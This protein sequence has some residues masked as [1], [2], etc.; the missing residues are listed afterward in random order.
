MSIT[1]ASISLPAEI[2]N[3]IISNAVAESAV[4]RLARRI[5]LPGHGAAVPVITGDPTAYF[6]DEGGVK[7]NSDATMT[8]KTMKGRTIAI[9]EPFSNQFRRDNQ[10]LYNEMVARLPKLLAQ[11]FDQEVFNGTAVSG[12]DTLKGATGVSI[13]SDVWAG[14]VAARAAVEAADGELNGWAMSNQGITKLLGEKTSGGLPVYTAGV[15]E[16]EY[17]RL[18]GEPIVR[19][20]KAYA[21]NTKTTDEVLGFAGDWT[22]ACY[23]IVDDIS[24][25]ISEDATLTTSS[26]TLNLFERN[27]F[28]VRV[29]FEVGF[30][31]AIAG[32]FVKLTGAPATNLQ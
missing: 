10:A 18:I 24:I 26:G 13:N 30:I 25:T 16:G 7:T 15:T 2:S 17:G 31:A 19:A 14:L 23:G 32:Q 9:I 27:M 1:N 29:E 11:R 22:K 28:A 3:E 21:A 12:F 4:M 20:K 5:D 8:T 6:V